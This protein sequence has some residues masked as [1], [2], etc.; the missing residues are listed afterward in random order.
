MFRNGWAGWMAAVLDNAGDGIMVETAERVVYA[1]HSYATLLGY[2]RP[3]ELMSQ[4]VAELV[5]IADADRLSRYG[6]SRMIGHRAP[7]TYDF[8]ALHKDGSPVRLQA[9]VSVTMQGAAA[10][11]MSIVRPMM[12][13]PPIPAHVPLAGPHDSLST[14]ERQVMEMLLAGKRPKAIAGE[15][16]ISENTV[17]THRA[18]MLEKI[19]LTNIR[20]LFRYALRHR[21]VDWSANPE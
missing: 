5:A 13:V 11:I 20:D 17:A 21:L 18:R 1:N 2:R 9:S 15:L 7:A 8:T 14:R 3:L 16:G 10:Y 4:R 12:P 6:R 19:G